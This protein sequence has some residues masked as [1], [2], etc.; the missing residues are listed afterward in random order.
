MYAIKFDGEKVK[1]IIQAYYDT[2]GKYP[3]LICNKET[4]KL[5]FAY[6]EEKP[7]DVSNISVTSYY[8]S[9]QTEI[10]HIQK[11]I[12][13]LTI[14]DVEYIEKTE[15]VN[16]PLKWNNATVLIDDSI[17]FGEVHIG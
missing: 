9:V 5:C 3:Y 11:P 16:K 12:R 8:S 2:N 13:S 14:N 7:N 6:K 10:A 17:E 4:A 1:N 15:D